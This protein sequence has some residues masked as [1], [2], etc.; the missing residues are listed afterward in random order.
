MDENYKLNNNH[1]YQDNQLKFVEFY[2]NIIN[3]YEKKLLNK[4][5]LN[6]VLGIS[7][8]IVLFL[9]LFLASITI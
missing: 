9:F 6:V 1:L 5:I 3:E 2:D 4:T 7:L 8:F